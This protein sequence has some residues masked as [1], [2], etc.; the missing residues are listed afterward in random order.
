M[1]TTRSIGISKLAKTKSPLASVPTCVRCITTA[2]YDAWT[3]R[4]GKTP[5]LVHAF[6]IATTTGSFA[7]NISS[8]AT[9]L[10]TLRTLCT[11]WAVGGHD[12]R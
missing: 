2:D 5:D 12:G 7:N 10:S 9:C 8:F 1:V 4:T 6:G 11:T 3:A